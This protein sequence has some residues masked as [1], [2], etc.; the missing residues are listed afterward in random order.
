MANQVFKSTTTLK[1]GLQVE[2]VSGKHMF[3]L[4]EPKELGGTDIAMNPVEALLG[5]LGACK[6]I[7]ARAFAKAHKID[8]IDLRIEL[9]GD[10][11]PDGFLG[12]NPEAK[13]G[14]SNIRSKY[15]FKSNSSEEDIAKFVDFIEVT[16]PVCDS[17]VNTPGMEVEF[18]IEK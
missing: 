8:L 12:A 3:M 1:E 6:C 17:M 4:D 18:V 16:C 15:Y 14:F 13:I 2:V 7:V 10:L 5:A 11:D 9:E